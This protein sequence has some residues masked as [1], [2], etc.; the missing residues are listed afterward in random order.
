VLV[1]SRHGLMTAD[2]EML[3]MLDEAAV[4]YQIALTKA[5]KIKAAELEAVHAKVTEAI[6]RRPAAYPQVLATSAEKQ[7]GLDDMRAVIAGLLPA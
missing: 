3:A 5:D 7:L 6:A 4:T 2:L 1:D